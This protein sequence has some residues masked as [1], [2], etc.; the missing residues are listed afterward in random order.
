MLFKILQFSAVFTLS[1]ISSPSL[2]LSWI[3]HDQ[4]MAQSL[5]LCIGIFLCSSVFNSAPSF[6]QMCPSCQTNTVTC[7]IQNTCGCLYR[8][9]YK[10]FAR[11][12]S[13][14]SLILFLI[15]L[16]ELYHKII[17]IHIEF[18]CCYYNYTANKNDTLPTYLEYSQY[19]LAFPIRAL[20]DMKFE[21][22]ELSS[23]M[24]CPCIKCFFFLWLKLS[25]I[26][27]TVFCSMYVAAWETLHLVYLV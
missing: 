8:T 4:I 7:S 24:I 19:D 18:T 14:G 20:E 11:T 23:K 15:I 5:L 26:F 9:F 10:G 2:C 21:F 22:L 3:Y 25:F 13:H 27:I 12:G 17:F 6:C 1:L 16:H